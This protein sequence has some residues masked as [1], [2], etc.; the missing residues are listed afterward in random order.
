MLSTLV[1]VV[2]ALVDVLACDSVAGISF[3]TGAREVA[4]VVRASGVRM[5]VV[6]VCL[7]LVD[8]RAHD[9]IA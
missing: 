8:V 6:G 7:A 9:T 3:D 4:D 1:G 2:V 5:A